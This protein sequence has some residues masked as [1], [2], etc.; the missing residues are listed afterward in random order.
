MIYPNPSSE[1]FTVRRL[2]TAGDNMDIKVYD[3]MGKLIRQQSNITDT[4]YKLNLAGVS[5]G[6]YFLH[7]NI[8]NKRLVKKL[9]LN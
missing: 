9:I 3:V 8:E 2:N 6:I 5:K 7:L 4:N 1:L